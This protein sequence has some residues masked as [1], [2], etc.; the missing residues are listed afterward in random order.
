VEVFDDLNA[1]EETFGFENLKVDSAEVLMPLVP[2]TGDDYDSVFVLPKDD[3][4][5]SKM[6][7]TEASATFI[8]YC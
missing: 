8:L 2:G 5:R 6:K 3:D 4:S 7:E 1:D